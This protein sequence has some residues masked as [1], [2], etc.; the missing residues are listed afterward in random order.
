MKGSNI[1]CLWRGRSVP[2]YTLV[3]SLLIV[4]FSCAAF[5]I[6][7]KK[8]TQPSNVSRKHNLK[9]LCV[10]VCVSPQRALW[11][12]ARKLNFFKYWLC[13]IGAK[14]AAFKWNCFPR[15]LGVPVHNSFWFLFGTSS[16][17]CGISTW[18]QL[19]WVKLPLSWQEGMIDIHYN[20]YKLTAKDF[21]KAE[22]SHRR[23]P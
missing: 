22:L 14:G 9:D 21:A 13:T 18:F 15:G 6:F 10:C 17:I 12:T 23:G 20:W 11:L 16:H 3:T 5:W 1:H 4:T 2:I 19:V 8:E 7:W